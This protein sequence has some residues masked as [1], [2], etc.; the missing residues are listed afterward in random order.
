MTP[1][2]VD[3]ARN[4][5]HNNTTPHPTHHTTTTTT[6]HTPTHTTTTP[7]HH[8]H[9]PPTHHH[10]P[11]HTHHTNNHPQSTNR[12]G[13]PMPPAGGPRETT[14]ARD[15]RCCGAGSACAARA[16]VRHAA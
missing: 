11:H 16:G 2:S 5:P 3:A 15:G 13:I 1:Y 10:N 7:H 4:R 6:T 14:P 12:A 8:T 9:T